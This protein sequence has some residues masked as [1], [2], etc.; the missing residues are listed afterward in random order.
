MADDE[1]FRWV[2][3]TA[4][5]PDR[6]P[7]TLPG[8]SEVRVKLVVAERSGIILGGQMSGG[9]SVG[10]LINIVALAIQKEVTVSELD[11]MQ[12]ATHPLLTS[13]PTVYPLINAAQ[14]ALAKLRA[15]AK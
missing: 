14:Q 13:S 3:A 1:K 7:G 11:M 6:H 9:V 15:G 12:I 2:S 10:E 8:A 5:A 4:S